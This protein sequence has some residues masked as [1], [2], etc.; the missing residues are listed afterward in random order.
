MRFK[1][2]PQSWKIISGL[3]VVVLSLILS[4]IVDVNFFWSGILMGIGIILFLTGYV[5]ARY[6]SNKIRFRQRN[7]QKNV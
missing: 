6:E 4:H 7:I 5:A 1:T 2:K 3:T